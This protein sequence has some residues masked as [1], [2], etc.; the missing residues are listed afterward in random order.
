ME[1]TSKPAKDSPEYEGYL[2][3]KLQ[4]LQTGETFAKLYGDD[5]WALTCAAEACRVE[6]EL[7]GRA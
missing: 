2:R 3:K 7:Q 1:E 6:L 4:D 5:A